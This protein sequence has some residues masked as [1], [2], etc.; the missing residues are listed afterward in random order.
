[1]GTH[2]TLPSKL[3]DGPLCSE[4]LKSNPHLTGESV[5][6]AFPDSKEGSLPFLFKVLSIGTALSI[7]AHPDKP[8]A[9]RLH[10]ERPDVYKG[11]LGPQPPRTSMMDYSAD[12]VDPNH[13]PEMAIALTPFL[14][15]L[16]FLPLPL[17]LL[18]LLTVPE[19]EPLIPQS[20]VDEL[21]ATLTLPSTRPADPFLFQP[22]AS[23]PNHAQKEALKKV[24]GALM[25]APTDKV[26]K[27][28]S[29]LVQRYK[30]NQDIAESEQ[31]LVDL[32]IMLDE[33]YPGDVG[34]LC[35]FLL[36]VVELKKGEA[37]FLGADMP[38][39]YIS[40][41]ERSN[42]TCCVLQYISFCDLPPTDLLS[43]I[44]SSAWPRRTTSSV[45]GSPPSSGT[46][47]PSCLCSHTRPDRGPSSSSNP[48]GL[49]P[50]TRPCCT[51]LRSTSFLCSS[52][53]STPGRRHPTGRSRDRVCAS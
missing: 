44:S 22:T 4:H 12:E 21:A 31:G 37:A 47:T 48:P 6:S 39:A 27:S 35:V 33:Q 11:A 19:L 10:K 8:L 18:H 51:I 2:P 28:I 40:G 30:S 7:Q 26:K 36:N 13:K 32:A 23:S 24:F 16:N 29:E 20:L 42:L 25:S 9:E 1:M 41:G 14:A 43:Q 5:T 49:G 45:L 3:E 50:T 15:F 46:W 34:V 52:S 17:V 53:T 38:H